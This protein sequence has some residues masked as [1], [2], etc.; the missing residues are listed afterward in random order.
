[1]HV[2]YIEGNRREHKRGEE[3]EGR[4]KKTEWPH[5]GKQ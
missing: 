5:K 1:M 4:R 2:G 3:R